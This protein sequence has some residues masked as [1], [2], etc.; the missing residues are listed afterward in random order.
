MKWFAENSPTPRHNLSVTA[1]VLDSGLNLCL[2]NQKTFESVILQDH[3]GKCFI[4]RPY[5]ESRMLCVP[6]LNKR[7]IFSSWFSSFVRECYYNAVAKSGR[8]SR[9]ANI[10]YSTCLQ[11]I[12][13]QV[14]I[15][16][17]TM[18]P[19]MSKLILMNL[20]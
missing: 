5:M 19:L 6:H 1:L 9:M 17:P 4:Y 14:S 18:Y 16:V 15:L 12:K 20:L 8:C 3:N 11:L 13:I 7:V 10:T 2:G